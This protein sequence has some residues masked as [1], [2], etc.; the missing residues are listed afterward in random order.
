MMKEALLCD[1]ALR[2][3]TA[4]FAQ[5]SMTK[6]TG[7]PGDWT[8]ETNGGSTAS[9]LACTP[10]TPLIVLTKITKVWKQRGFKT[11]RGDVGSLPLYGGTFVRSYSVSINAEALRRRAKRDATPAEAM[12]RAWTS[13]LQLH[14]KPVSG[15][16]SISALQKASIGKDQKKFQRRRDDNKN[17]FAFLG[18][19]HWGREETHPKDAAFLGKTP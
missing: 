13:P 7:R 1:T 5:N 4:K 12:A 8:M 3:D 10:C 19:G 17:I 14:A 11:S 2:C 16:S 15:Q 18:R 9:Y 6:M